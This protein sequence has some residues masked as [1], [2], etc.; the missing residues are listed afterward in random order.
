MLNLNLVE[1]FLKRFLKYS[2]QLIFSAAKHLHIHCVAYVY[3]AFVWARDQG[4]HQNFDPSLLHYKF[5][6]I[7]IG[8]K[9]K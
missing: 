4:N 3:A 8:M 6:L 7:F 9:Q 1:I 2:E 5:R